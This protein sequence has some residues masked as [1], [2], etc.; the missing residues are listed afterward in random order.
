MQFEPTFPHVHLRRSTN[1]ASARRVQSA[2]QHADCAAVGRNGSDVVLGA[3]DPLY[4]SA[5]GR[6]NRIVGTR[7]HALHARL[8]RTGDG[9]M[10]ETGGTEIE[11]RLQEWPMPTVRWRQ[12]G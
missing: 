4:R 6:G 8:T 5:R 9:V 12:R 11:V 7:A 1:R 10:I 2:D 3:L